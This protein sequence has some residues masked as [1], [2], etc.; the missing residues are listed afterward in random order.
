MMYLKKKLRKFT[1]QQSDKIFM[2]KLNKTCVKNYRTLKIWKK[3]STE[4]KSWFMNWINDVKN[5]LISKVIYR[6]SAIF[7]IIQMTWI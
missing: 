5:F 1:K 7:I 3:T 2:S 6:L 4:K